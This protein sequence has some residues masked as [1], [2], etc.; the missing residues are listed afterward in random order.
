MYRI[1]NGDN[2][3]EM[4]SLDDNSVDSIV[5]D[6][7]YGLTDK[8][9]IM[10]VLS[11]WMNNE[12]FNGGKGFMGKEWDGFVPSP[13]VW[14]ECYR[15]L[16]PGGYLLS[17]GGT[18][19]YDLMV[20]SIR[21]AGFEIRDMIGWIRGQGFTKSYDIA[22]GMKK[23]GIEDHK[24][25]GWGTALKPAIEPIV[26]ARKPLS[27]KSIIDNLDKW[28]VGAI[29]IDD[30][31]ISVSLDDKGGHWTRKR[32]ST[33][34]LYHGGWKDSGEDFGHTNP[35]G[36]RFPANIILD[37]SDEVET[38]FPHTKS[39]YSP[40]FDGGRYNATVYGDYGKSIIN[41]ST[42]YADSG[43][44]SRFFYCAKASRADRDNGLEHKENDHPTVKPIELMRY[45]VKL[46]T[47]PNG[48]VLDPF[49]GSGS[50]GKA[51]VMDG[52]DFIGIEM[53]AEYYSIAKRRIDDVN[54]GE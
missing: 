53:N 16:K 31:R 37:G 24:W 2:V 27:E 1:I 9:D 47:P 46:V 6:P 32:D 51:C 21:L 20:I 52:F 5:T 38:I 50:T 8:I 45:L 54:S 4:K 3:E 42:I 41:P 14:K 23:R 36:G 18:R 30:S 44:A 28:G 10:D 26:M 43:S 34:T 25:D 40:G 48:M 7:P 13:A 29:N 35:N 22:K 39:G 19:T 11:S 17:F 12:H 49:M 33:E 15:V